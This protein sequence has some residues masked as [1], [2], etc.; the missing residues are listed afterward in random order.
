MHLRNQKDSEQIG[1][2]VLGKM[3]ETAENFLGRTVSKAI[4]TVPAY[5]ND[6][7]RQATKVGRLSIFLIEIRTSRLC[8]SCR[9]GRREDRWPRGSSDYQRAYCGRACLRYNIFRRFS[10]F[11]FQVLSRAG[12][13]KKA[14]G[15]LIAVFD[16]G[17]GTF[18]VSILE[19]SGGV[20][21]VTTA[22]PPPA[23]P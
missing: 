7:Q 21:E 2:M 16:L 8:C 1:S 4:V 17:G 11:N 18:D 20:F 22:Q 10:P 15:K 6:S 3:K 5:F 14:D 9:T 23:L 12:M 13:D 19:I